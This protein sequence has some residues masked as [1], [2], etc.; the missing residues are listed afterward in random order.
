M[1]RELLNNPK[2][3]EPGQLQKDARARFPILVQTSHL[4]E[5]LKDKPLSNASTGQKVILGVATYSR[6]ELELLD[7]L[8]QSHLDWESSTEISVFDIT[9]CKNS[10]DLRKYLLQDMTNVQTPVVVIWNDGRMVGT[11]TGLY[12]VRESLKKANILS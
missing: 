12:M 3:I 1:F 2:C 6:D 8:E 10:C 4:R 5:R 7:N 9:E 11:Q